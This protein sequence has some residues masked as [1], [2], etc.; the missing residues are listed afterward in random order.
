[1]RTGA[2]VVMVWVVATVSGAGSHGWIRSYTAGPRLLSCEAERIPKKLSSH[3]PYS[4]VLQ[5]CFL[6]IH[7]SWVLIWPGVA[8]TDVTGAV[9]RFAFHMFIRFDLL[10][11]LY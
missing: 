5:Q 4:K 6:P 3:Q 2:C 11:S 10:S 9:M 7:K 8:S 1:M